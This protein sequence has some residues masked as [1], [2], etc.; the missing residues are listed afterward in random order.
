MAN[1]VTDEPSVEDRT[2]LIGLFRQIPGQISRLV[3]D[4]IRAAQ[5]ELSAKLKDAGLGAGLLAGAAVIGL[6]AFG[7]LVATAILALAIV[8]PA[9]LAAL[10]VAVLLLAVAGALAFLGIKKLKAGVPPV[11]TDSIESV[12]ADI[13]TVKGTNP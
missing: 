1:T 7:V 9:W 8:L 13:R 11:P 12:K 6:Y 3:R 2:S 5:V 10:I 4:E